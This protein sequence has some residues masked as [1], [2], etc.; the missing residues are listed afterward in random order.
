MKNTRKKATH[1]IE[2][3]NSILVDRGKFFRFSFELTEV[4]ERGQPRLHGAGVV[5]HLGLEVP[6]VHSRM[7]KGDLKIRI[8]MLLLKDSIQ[9][10][11]PHAVGA[12]I[13]AIA[14]MRI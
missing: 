6:L 7:A 8:N 12:E 5:E 3:K 10:V 4:E 11:Q 13:I 9:Q 14:E 1:I 2:Q